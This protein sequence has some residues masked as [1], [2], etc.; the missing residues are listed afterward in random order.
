[1]AARQRFNLTPVGDGSGC[2]KV[3]WDVLYSYC[4]AENRAKME[5]PG[6]P[7]SSSVPG[8]I[9]DRVAASAR[10]A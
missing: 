2:P 5:K 4:N 9:G 7:P 10:A 6:T 3:L 8:N 1:M